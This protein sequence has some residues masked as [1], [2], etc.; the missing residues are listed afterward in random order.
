MQ[1]TDKLFLNR[2]INPKPEVSYAAVYPAWIEWV[3]S[4]VGSSVRHLLQLHLTIILT[5]VEAYTG[6]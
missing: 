6:L 4:W 2:K 3:G 1:I 5:I